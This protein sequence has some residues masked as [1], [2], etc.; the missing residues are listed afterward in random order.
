MELPFWK[1]K[2]RDEELNEELQAHLILSARERSNP[3]NRANAL[4]STLAA[5]SAMKLWRAKLLAICG[6]GDG[7]RI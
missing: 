2:Q 5:N 7:S 6:A 1:R 3:A 4:H